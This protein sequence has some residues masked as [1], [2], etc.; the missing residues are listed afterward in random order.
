MKKFIQ[1]HAKL[2]IAVL[3][4]AL[5]TVGGTLALMLVSSNIVTNNF[6]AADIDTEIEEVL[7][8]DMSKQVSIINQGPSDAYVRARIMVSGF[9]ASA[10]TADPIDLTFANTVEEAEDMVKN[11]R[12]VCLVMPN[13]SNEEQESK[14]YYDDQHS[15]TLTD[16]Y[17]YLDVLPGTESGATVDE[18][19]TPELLQKV[20]LSE[21]LEQ[22]Q[23]FL[24]KF[25]VTIYHESVLA[26]NQPETITLD[27][28]KGA[29]DAAQPSATT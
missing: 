12:M 24:E 22:D 23:E 10:G 26:I 21:D 28:V 13:V 5:V 27:V 19:K 3:A 8:S 1:K 11:G 25:S 29:F 18:R 17:Y 6:T 7:G 9:N 4:L 20:V 16:F 2:C 15:V 14:W